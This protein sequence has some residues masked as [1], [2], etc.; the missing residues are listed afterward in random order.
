MVKCRKHI[1][2]LLIVFLFYSCNN[3]KKSESNIS[4][5]ESNNRN[6]TYL[7][8]LPSSLRRNSL[9]SYSDYLKLIKENRS[10]DSI[11]RIFFYNVKDYYD[12]KPF[13]TSLKNL[14]YLSFRFTLKQNELSFDSIISTINHLQRTY[15]LD[16]SFNSITGTFSKN[17]IKYL[18]LKFDT[19]LSKDSCDFT[20]FDSLFSLTI[21]TRQEILPKKIIFPFSMKELWLSDNNIDIK[22]FI[23]SANA[24]SLEKLVISDSVL[25]DLPASLRKFNK[26]KELNIIN[27]KLGALLRSRQKDALVKIKFMQNQF[28]PKDCHISYYYLKAPDQLIR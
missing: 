16:I 2:F 20:P 9:T 3:S 22:S 5:S 19:I 14:S 8:S 7:D 26:L 17:R 11:Y 21:G 10:P 27:T 24:P 23:Q 15:V 25:Y 18:T 13:L 1:A 12:I 28:L 4:E 6:I